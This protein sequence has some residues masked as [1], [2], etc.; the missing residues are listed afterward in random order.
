M[1][2]PLIEASDATR[3]Q[4]AARERLRAWLLELLTPAAHA[5]AYR[6]ARHELWLLSGVVALALVLRWVGLR[7]GLP[8]FHH[9]DEVLISGSARG[10]LQRGDDLPSNYFY[11]APLMRL[12]ALAYKAALSLGLPGASDAVLRDEVYLRLV[13]R[14]VAS[15][16]SASGVV[17]SYL[18]T[19]MTWRSGRA[20]LFSALLYATAQELVSHGRFLVT[21]ASVVALTTWV[22]ALSAC[23][24]T[25]RALLFAL[26]AVLI[27]GLTF[28]FKLTGLATVL[29]PT[30]VL[31]LVTARSWAGEAGEKREREAWALTLANRALLL[32][33]V[34]LV[35]GVFLALNPH[36]RDHWRQALGDWEGI[37]RHYREG[38]VKPWGEREPGVEHLLAALSY[39]LTQSLHSQRIAAT[40][41]GLLGLAG[42]A[43][44]LRRANLVALLGCVHALS[45]VV[46]MAMPNRAYLARAYLPALPVLC[47]GFGVA[48]DGLLTW[49]SRRS[50]SRVVAMATPWALVALVSMSAC[51]EAVLCARLSS[52]ARMRALD[53]VA[54]VARAEGK[55]LSVVPDAALRGSLALGGHGQLDRYLQRPSVI[56]LAEASDAETA[57]ASGAD[58]VLLSS[59]RDLAR[60]FPYEEQWVF[61]EVPGYAPFARFA[62]NPYEHRLDI[63]PTWDGRVSA[64]LLRRI[65]P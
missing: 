35:L 55:T 52:D 19:R 15:S 65:G 38:H 2:E 29:I 54:A 4:R 14:V 59:Y 61:S 51:V 5:P 25:T 56:L 13:G 34:P 20:A 33:A 49:L 24:V 44:M 10:M 8:Y 22:L 11:G 48:A 7:L 30:G 50:P 41:L 46:A 6:P 47:L 27:A 23:F 18:L 62:L 3:Q 37:T 12:T 9:W 36:V 53:A 28:A 17:A 31:W 42:L 45:V 43:M 40:L 1:S 32:A 21:D 60:S 16:L 57:R 26:A 64:V 39:I 63:V 58:F